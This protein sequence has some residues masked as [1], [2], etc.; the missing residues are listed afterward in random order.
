M[1]PQTELTPPDIEQAIDD[2]RYDENAWVA[3]SR[4]D[5]DEMERYIRREFSRGAWATD[6]ELVPL[7]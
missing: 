7:T 4:D 6:T 2:L 5:Y 1:G 3:Y